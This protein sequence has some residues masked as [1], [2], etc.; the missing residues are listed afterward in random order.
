MN[1]KQILSVFLKEGVLLSPETLERVNEE[2]Y[3]ETLRSI[4]NGEK[5]GI[6]TKTETKPEKGKRVV[7]VKEFLGYY[8]GKYDF[9]KEILLKKMDAVSI[10][11]GKKIF[12]KTSVIGRVKERTKK[13]FLIEDVTGEIE[14]TTDKKEIEKGDVIGLK[15]WF[16]EGGFM[17]DEFVW[18]DIPLTNNP[19]LPD[20]LLTEKTSAKTTE[21]TGKSVLLISLDSRKEGREN[22]AWISVSEKGK[23]FLVLVFKPEERV[24]PEDFPN[25]F[26]RRELPH[27]K[28][29]GIHI[30]SVIKNIPNVVWFVQNRKN[31][32]RNYRG[33]VVVSTD[34]ESFFEYRKNEGGKFNKI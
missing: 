23:G 7:G 6:N 1:K 4:K 18:P 14:V 15:G 12:S 21:K 8:N 24:S 11:K 27:K 22:P 19:E 26:K 20:F 3:E 13:G 34:N 5:P 9:L 10:N 30:T 16:K 29:G 2:N 32:T 33:V 28:D 25:F 31:W 17:P